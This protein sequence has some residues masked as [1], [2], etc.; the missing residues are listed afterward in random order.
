MLESREISITEH[1]LT[2]NPFL[3]VIYRSFVV[4]DIEYQPKKAIMI[5]KPKGCHDI[6][7]NDAKNWKYID[8]VIDALCEKYNY[9]YIRT[10]IFESSELTPV[11]AAVLK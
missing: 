10:P 8:T 1:D 4:I 3:I 2:K 5:T 6:Y 7:G 9:K 11:K